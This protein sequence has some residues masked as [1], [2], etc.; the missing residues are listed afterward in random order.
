MV[1]SKA[2]RQKI[3][4]M[5]LKGLST[6][7]IAK[8][9]ACSDRTVRNYKA[10]LD[11][12]GSSEPKK[13]IRTSKVVS[14]KL[15]RRIVRNALKSATM[16]L[17]DIVSAIG[18]VVSRSTVHK[19][20]KEEGVNYKSMVRKPK[21]KVEHRRKRVEFA[22]EVKGD[23]NIAIGRPRSGI[24][25]PEEFF[26]NWTFSDECSVSLI[27][28]GYGKKRWMRLKDRYR[29]EFIHGTVQ[30]GGGKVMIWGMITYYGPGPLKLVSGTLNSSQYIS[31]LRQCVKPEMVKFL[32]RTNRPH[33]FIQDN[34]PCH[35]SSAV[36]E[37]FDDSGIKTHWW[38]SRSPD[39]NPIENVWAWV[40]MRLSRLETKPQDTPELFE[41]IKEIWAE[42]SIEMCRK[43]IT[44]MPKRLD[45]VIKGHGRPI[46]Y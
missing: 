6:A 39:L 18:N 7:T 5:L 2:N 20:L 43:L 23:V 15:R 45:L 33:V 22:K 41:K 13:R 12:T 16:S 8:S 28:P 27:A 29:D 42:I 44:S 26:Q 34:A 3:T 36:M 4:S 19:V 24:T 30:G 32:R 35:T 11:K 40:K 37:Y 46:P 10:K 21:L 9:V 38:P 31:I 1:L 17:N 14:P 25:T